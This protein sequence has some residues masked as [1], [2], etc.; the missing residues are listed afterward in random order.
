MGWLFA[1]LLLGLVFGATS[2]L[3]VWALLAYFGGHLLQLYRLERWL[4]QGKRHQ[5]PESSGV[6]GEVF[7]LIYL[8]QQRNRKGKK[9]LAAILARF[10]EATYALPDATVVLTAH[11]EIEWFNDAARLLLGLRSPVDIGQRIDNL[12][13]HPLFLDYIATLSEESGVEVVSP[14]DESR[15]LH[16]RI[17]PYGNNRNLLVARE[18]TERLRL[19]QMRQDFVANVSHEL[20][21]PLT[22]VNGYLETLADSGD[23]AC[24]AWQPTLV[25]MQQQT[26]RMRRIVEDLLL[27]SRLDSGPTNHRE[28]VDVAALLAGLRQGITLL[29]E[30]K[31]IQLRFEVEPVRTLAGKESELF[32]AFNNLISNAIRYTPDGGEVT[33]RWHGEEGGACLEVSDSGI[34]IAARHI[35]RLT[36]RFYRIDVGRSRDT[37]GT[38]LGLAIVKHVLLRHGAT[39]EIKSEP[40]RGSR[41]ICHF[42]SSALTG[43]S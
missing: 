8:L 33:V 29:A 21:T 2:Q 12:I 16:I 24:V 7:H 42:P 32:S 31:G 13:R 3:L 37:G 30:H 41:F 11:H 19:E 17:V 22:V 1:G 43:R 38:G 4:A 23:E 40:G 39:L 36:E 27:L 35:P 25:V 14:L 26:E 34:G 28:S 18:I 9:K 15:V 6:W 5:P 20:R 10:Q